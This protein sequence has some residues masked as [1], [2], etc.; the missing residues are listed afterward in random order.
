MGKFTWLGQIM[1]DIRYGLRQLLRNPGF[2]AVAVI[3]LAL[4]IGANTA[5]FSVLDGVVLASLPYRQPDRLVMIWGFSD[6]LKHNIAMSYLDFRDWQR[7]AKSVDQMAAHTGRSFN[8]TNPG[9]PEHLNGEEVS[10]GYFSTLGV[11]M[12]AG[13][14]FD[15]REDQRGGPR[16]VI[17]SDGL[18]RERFG[19]SADV[20]GKVVTLDA[21]DYTI[22]GVAP[23]GFRFNG[24]TTTDVYTP[25]AQGDPVELDDRR[26]HSFGAVARM[27]TGVA[28]AEAQAEMS[29]VQQRIDDLYPQ[30]ER[31]LGVRVQ[32]LKEYLIGPVSGTLF[33]LFG[34][35]G[36]ILLI[37]CANVAN[38]L[39][40]RGVA[41]G[42]EFAV[43]LALGASRGRILRQ[44]VTENMLLAIVGGGAG[45][46]L[47]KWGVRPMLALAP[48]NLP[49]SGSVE[50][51]SGALLFALG[52]SIGVGVLF[53]LA[54]ALRSWKTDLQAS[55]RSGGRGATAA[56]HRAQSSLAVLQMALTLVVLVGAGLLFRS[57]RKLWEVNPGF[58]AQHVLSFQVGLSPSKTKTPP[59][60][61]NAWADLIAR[62]REVPGVESADLTALVPMS[63]AD[64][65]GPFWVGENRPV[66]LA[67][68]PRTLFYWV[69]PEYART[70]RIPL[71]A[72]RFLT[73]DDTV[74]S[75]RVVVIDS[76]LARGFFPGTDPVGKMV[77]IPLWGEARVVGVVGHV[78][79]WGPNEPSNFVQNQMYASFYELPD[80]FVGVFS[81]YMTVAVRT[82]L[83]EAEV[84]PEIRKAVSASGSEEPIYGVKSMNEIVSASL[85]PERFP[86]ILLSAFALLALALASVGIYGVISY[87][88]S[89][90]VH[91]IGI[92]MALGAGR[93]SVFRMVIGQGLRLAIAGVAIGAAVSFALTRMLTGYSHLLYGVGSGDPLTFVTVAAGLTLVAVLACY[94]PA[95]RATRVD[96]IVALRCE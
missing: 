24:K 92:R 51:N 82:S 21:A 66:S 13:R 83:D 15:P 76:N 42:R 47:A 49:R 46:A 59:D 2:T 1:Q 80:K 3:T 68:A 9:N 95:R 69:G 44:M 58:E 53:G 32:S 61:R 7:D 4:G 63:Q 22:V 19:G 26:I 18:W 87:S 73:A 96:P 89:Q 57:I 17:V 23:E 74:K 91:E 36:L 33:L 38:L 60:T 35:V 70:M 81:P 62:V 5:I 84:I 71:L 16:S 28:L 6:K 27:K 90:R 75:E 79:H 14:E 67:E 30:I 55:L 20:L 10:A 25:L 41:R 77:T 37:A 11:E 78:R 56:H 88:M 40:A 86:M 45:L 64:N 85:A 52:V 12:S 93:G 54:P 43:R 34:A 31:G 72:G 65:S 94:V 29:A 48:A 39:L 50:V 8:L